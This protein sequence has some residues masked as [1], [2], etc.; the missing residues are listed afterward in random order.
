M[1]IKSVPFADLP[2]GC[3]VDAETREIEFY[4][5]VFGNRD[6]T[7]D[8]VD[9]GA[10]AKT[11]GERMPKKLIKVF[12]NHWDPVGMPVELREDAYGLYCKAKIDRTAIGDETLEQCISGTLAHAS[13]MYRV[14]Q[15]RREE[16]DGEET[17]HLVELKLYETGPVNFPA[18]ELA[19]IL[20]A[21]KSGRA[22]HAALLDFALS[23]L[24]EPA[25]AAL[26]A[27]EARSS[28][29]SYER[30]ELSAAYKD[31]EPFVERLRAL[32]AADGGPDPM[33]GTTREKEE[34]AD[35]STKQGPE[36]ETAT[37]PASDEADLFSTVEAGL[38]ALQRLRDARA[39]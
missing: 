16:N 10:F 6:S 36:H 37:T 39:A 11:I 30:R 18:N 13:F 12:R 29:T 14:L 23:D 4:G 24:L 17:L 7:G 26:S 1:R 38:Q 5:S 8:V 21:S 31:L 9:R 20:A 22:S 15:W 25:K 3:K 35:G 19:T 33:K 34:S 2:Q 27:L 28:L 32:E